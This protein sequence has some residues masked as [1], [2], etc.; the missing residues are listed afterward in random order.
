MLQNVN[1]TAFLN[2][3]YKRRRRY[4]KA[5][6]DDL[7]DI[8]S[9]FPESNVEVLSS[10]TSTVETAQPTGQTCESRPDRPNTNAH[11]PPPRYPSMPLDSMQC[12]SF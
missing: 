11:Y 9:I 3:A 12:G 6:V 7:C 2:R 1:I 8:V 10:D 5:E 4:A